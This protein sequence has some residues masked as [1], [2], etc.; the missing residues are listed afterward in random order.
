M[1]LDELTPGSRPGVVAVEIEKD[2]A[3]FF[4]HD[5]ASFRTETVPFEP[6]I[7]LSSPEQMTGYTGPVRLEPLAG[8]M[9]LST[10]ARFPDVSG[11]FDA[12]KFL[13]KQKDAWTA[14]SDLTR[15]ALAETGT[16]LFTGME[17]GELRR[18]AFDIETLT[19]P[20][21]DFPNADRDGDEIIVISLHDS[22]GRELVISQDSMSEKELLTA[23]VNAVREFDPD[24]IEGH[25]SCR[26]D[27]PYIET[28]AKRHKVKLAVGRDGSTPSKRS[29]RFSLAD[30]IVNYTRYE[31]Y[32][33]HHVDTLHLAMFHDQTSRNLESYGLKYLAKFFGFAAPDRTYVDGADITS[34]WSTDRKRL[35]DYALDDVRETLAL[36]GLLS[37][38]YFYQTRLLPLSYQ[39]AVIRGNGACLDALLTAA[40]L[41]RRHSLPFPEAPR[42]YAGALTRAE[43]SGVFRNVWHCDVRS[44]YPSILLAGQWSPSRDELGEFLRLLEALRAFRLDA[45]DRA[46]A[47]LGAER[48]H[49]QALQSAFKV[50][51]NSFYGYLGFAQGS[52]NDFDLAEKVAAR[53]REILTLMLDFLTKA[54]ANVLEMDTDGI[55][56]QPPAGVTDPGLFIR[57]IQAVLPTGID[58]ELDAVYQAMFSYKSKNYALLDQDGN[59]GITGAALKSRGLEPFQRHF[60]ATLIGRLLHGEKEKVAADYEELRRKIAE[61][62]IPLAQLAKTETLSDSPDAYRRKIE[63]GT[64]RRAAAFELAI[65]S[66]RSYQSGDTVT[67]YIPG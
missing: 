54:G 22:T 51:I 63:A 50:M 23:F 65:R 8:D 57:E 35:L 38:S 15:Q 59:V 34:I 46:R 6:F 64:G 33:R 48:N 21:F 1:Q 26:F 29:S 2:H 28:R 4:F 9:V 11:Y 12:R 17:F 20:G 60:I 19:T 16:R 56:F 55:Y 37:P 41:A 25:N 40:Y 30:R 24:V 10:V 14:W 44:L 53:G 49:Y 42:P 45:K 67:Y 43:E 32:G 66:G 61:R 3:L 47:A 18:L 7:F 5:G 52:F 62:E 39:D 36:G 13:G 27:W 58:V 31:I